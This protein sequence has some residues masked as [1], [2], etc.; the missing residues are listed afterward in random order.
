MLPYNDGR[1]FF[2][3]F[4]CCRLCV[5]GPNSS[6]IIMPQFKNY[7]DRSW[8]H[9]QIWATSL[10][11]YYFWF[12]I[13]RHQ[14]IHISTCSIDSCSKFNFALIDAVLYLKVKAFSNVQPCLLIIQ[15]LQNIHKI[16]KSIYFVHLL[17]WQSM[18]LYQ[19]WMCVCLPQDKSTLNATHC[20][21]KSN[22]ALTEGGAIY[23]LV[24][25]RI[26]GLTV[27]ENRIHHSNAIVLY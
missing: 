17:F 11:Q 2:A 1:F 18:T 19:M 24:G 26:Q 14:D 4:V 20:T 3:Q 21:F 5:R 16:T 7:S 9:P 13:W 12:G 27:V 10:A 25:P 22:N 8:L 23:A 6:Q 15:I